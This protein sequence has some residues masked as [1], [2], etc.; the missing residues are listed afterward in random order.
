MPIKPPNRTSPLRLRILKSAMDL[1]AERGMGS[2]A[3]KDIVRKAGTTQPMLYYY[4]GCKNRLCASLFKDL[5]TD[6][7][8]GSG[9]ILLAETPLE[10]K[11]TKLFTFYSCFFASRPGAARFVLQ[12]FL[13]PSY[14]RVFRDIRIEAQGEHELN[15]RSMLKYHES[16]GEVSRHKEQELLDIMNGLFLH[17]MLNTK[18]TTEKSA[19]NSG[20]WKLAAFI[21]RGLGAAG[22]LLL[23]AGLLV[24]PAAAQETSSATWTLARCLSRAMEVNPGMLAAREGIKAAQGRN[25]MAIS[26]FMPKLNWNSLYIDNSYVPAAGSARAS[27]GSDDFYLSS[28]SADMNLF[29]WRMAPLRRTMKANTR[30]ARLKLASTQNDLTLD[31]KK[32]FYSALYTK[33]LLAIAQAAES[34]ALENLETARNLYA[35]GR[36]ST[37]DV[38]RASVRR[39]NARTAAISARNSQTM[40]LENLRLL[41]SLPSD[42]AFDIDGVFPEEEFSASLSEELGLARARR[43]ELHLAKAGEDLQASAKELARAGFLPTVFTNFSYSWEGRQFAPGSRDGDYK[44]W[45]GKVGISIPLF[46][47]M[48]SIGRYKAEK[49]AL[50]QVKEQS[51]A[52]EDGVVMEVRQHYYSLANALE[53]LAAQKENVET[54]AENLRIAQERYKMGLLS[55]LDLKDAELSHIESRTQQ[56]KALYDYNTAKTSLERAAGFP[57]AAD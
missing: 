17:F 37:F 19:K 22:V 16:T 42:E 2:V 35:Q 25:M 13:S 12:G 36:V 23:A 31:V 11:L 34:V 8:K 7:I 24:M 50:S 38:S 30:V 56:I 33:Q 9:P 48:F 54:A 28:L 15:L 43:P 52:A 49:A 53:S 14:G 57:A 44:Y 29:S 26:E 47:G 21:R 55:L 51:K 39:V 40:A 46:D 27:Y 41:L 32:S 1:F 18:N 3:V 45:T 4:F 5:L 20:P 10:D 6:I